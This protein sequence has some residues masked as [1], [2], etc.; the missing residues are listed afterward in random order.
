MTYQYILHL[1][2]GNS[3][4]LTEESAV[5]IGCSKNNPHSRNIESNDPNY[6]LKVAGK[7]PDEFMEARRKDIEREAYRYAYSKINEKYT[8]TYWIKR[9]LTPP[10][11]SGMDKE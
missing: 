9:L 8:L 1:P 4:S 7:Y 2:S 3:E 11:S 6:Q 5:F 10:Q